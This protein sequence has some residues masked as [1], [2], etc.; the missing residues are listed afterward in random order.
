MIVIKHIDNMQQYI[1]ERKHRD[2]TIGF[3]PTMGYLHKGH[4]SLLEKAREECDYVIA[5]IFVNPLQFGPNED[6]DQYPRDFERDKALVNTYGVDAIFVP[7]KDEMYP[8]ES[9]CQLTVMRRTDVLCGKKRPGHFDGVVTVLTKLFH[10]IQPDRVYFGQKDAQQ[11]A[12]VHDLIEAFNFPI[13]L[14]A[15]PTVREEDGLAKSSRNVNLSDAERK[16]APRLYDQL[17]TARKAVLTG[18]SVESVKKKLVYSLEG[19]EHGHLDYA[20]ILSYP[21]LKPIESLDQTIIIAIAY[22]FEKAR[23]IDNIIIKKSEIDL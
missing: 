6:Y 9:G 18:E 8:T 22:Q 3:V 21:E 11:V 4:A 20:E 14:V 17:L 23:L 5:S 16:D 15:C 10:I 7:N 13:E 19:I 1:K 2:I 12:I